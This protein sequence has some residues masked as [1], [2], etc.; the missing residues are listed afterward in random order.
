MAHM[1]YARLAS[2]KAQILTLLVQ[3]TN[4][5]A[6]RS[7]RVLSVLLLRI[8]QQ[9]A[10]FTTQRTLQGNRMGVLFLPLSLL[11]LRRGRTREREKAALTK[12]LRAGQRAC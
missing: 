8:I 10:T 2:T 3:S 7:S 6:A 4:T 11:L 1:L 12:V 5:D 9:A